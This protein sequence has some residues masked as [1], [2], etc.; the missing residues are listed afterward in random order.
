MSCEV[1]NVVAMRNVQLDSRIEEEISV[2]LPSDVKYSRKEDSTT[3][4]IVFRKGS[5]VCYDSC[6]W[7][8]PGHVA[9]HCMS[10]LFPCLF[11][12]LEFLHRKAG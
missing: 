4:Q 11:L 2:K 6:C 5:E 3:E 1:A 12:D 8:Q 7:Q 10:S 9:K